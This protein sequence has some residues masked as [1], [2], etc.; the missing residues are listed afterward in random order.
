M[1]ERENE[2]DNTGGNQ[3]DAGGVDGEALRNTAADS[4]EA[5]DPAQSDGTAPADGTA[6]P[7]AAPTHEAV[8]IG[9]VDEGEN[10]GVEHHGQDEGRGTLTVS[11]TQQAGLSDAQEQRLP[12]MAQNNA[13]EVDKVAGIVAQTRSDVSVEPVERV[14][15]VLKQRLEQSGIHLPDEEIAELAR[16]VTTG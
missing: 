3:P 14:V 6:P 12:A 10:V 8:G 13:P 15:E 7:A 9:V 16:Q 4:P 5:T 1:T 11:E 2:F